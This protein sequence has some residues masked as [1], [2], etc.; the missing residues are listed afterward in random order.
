MSLIRVTAQGDELP[1]SPRDLFSDCIVSN[2]FVFISGQH[3]GAPDGPVGGADV[4]KQTQEGLR[5]IIVLLAKAG[6]GPQDVV[7]V[8]I[9]LTDL[10]QRAE[11]SRARREVFSE[12]TPCS[13]LIGVNGLVEPGLLVEIEAVAALP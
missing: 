8:T 9:Y 1:A 5:R 4:F 12:P 3:A 2:G 11:V 6:V 13:T 10:S 7:K